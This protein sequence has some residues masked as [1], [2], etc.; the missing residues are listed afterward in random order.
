MIEKQG[1]VHP[2]VT[3]DLEESRDSK[4]AS[5]HSNRG[6]VKDIKSYTDE[7]IATEI[8]RLDH[9]DVISKVNKEAKNTK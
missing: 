5:S 3:P 4:N 9:A 1:I 6:K 7:K 8:K 2:D